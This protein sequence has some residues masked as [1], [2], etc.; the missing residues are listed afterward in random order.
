[1]PAFNISYVLSVCE[2]DKSEK[3]KMEEKNQLLNFFIGC[4]V[5]FK[6]AG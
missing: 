2:N 1:M 6:R 4:A 3:K 5:R